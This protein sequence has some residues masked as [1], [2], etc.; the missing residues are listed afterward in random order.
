MSDDRQ[1]GSVGQGMTSSESQSTPYYNLN[2]N[3][4]MASPL[5]NSNLGSRNS[6]VSA[7]DGPQ[8]TK[9]VNI[10]RAK[11]IPLEEKEFNVT[12]SHLQ[13]LQHNGDLTSSQSHPDVDYRVH[14]VNRTPADT[15]TT[16]VISHRHYDHPIGTPLQQDIER[17]E[18]K[19]D[20]LK[21]AMTMWQ[22][23]S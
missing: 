15:P 7:I 18:N 23:A 6:P 13:A 1:F 5:R 3:S 22:V 11:L 21:T 4:T 8:R 12:A 14:I 9:T 17:L 2:I 10:C 20:T 16:A 19:I